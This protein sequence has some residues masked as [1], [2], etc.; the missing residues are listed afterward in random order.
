M[1]ALLLIDLP[2]TPDA[3]V[4]WLHWDKERASVIAEGVLANVG[5]L[6]SLADRAEGQACYVAKW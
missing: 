5:E 6:A 2:L 3:P 4:A 1:T